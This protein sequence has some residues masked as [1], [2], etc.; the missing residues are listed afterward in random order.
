[1][2]SEEVRFMAAN[3]FLVMVGFP[4]SGKSTYAS[5]LAASENAIVFSSDAFRKELYGSEAVQ[6]RNEEVYNTLMKRMI[7]ALKAGESVIFDAMNIS[8]KYRRSTLRMIDRYCAKKLAYLMATPF[9]ECLARNAET[10]RHVP[11]EVIKKE[12]KNKNK[13]NKEKRFDDNVII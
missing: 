10:D 1:M 7:E 2:H 11:E 13:Q 3:T 8:S 4:G 5:K 9:A 12:N 6:D